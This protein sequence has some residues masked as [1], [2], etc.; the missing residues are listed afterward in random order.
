M[1]TGIIEEIGTV[2][3]AR[4]TEITVAAKKVIEDVHLGDSICVNGTC[5]T[6]T[7]FAAQTFTVGLSPE[8]LRRTNLINLRPGDPVN[9]EPALPVGGRMG[10]HYVQGHVDGVGRLVS[11]TPEG[12]SRIYTFSAPPELM[13]Y[14][15][16]KGFIALDGI[17]LTVVNCD[18][19]TFS[20]SMIPFTQRSVILG[21]KKPGYVVNIEVDILGKYVEK[22]LSGAPEKSSG[23]TEE[24]LA[25]YGFL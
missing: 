18:A 19:T 8:T 14:V 7:A 23:L 5:L 22:L 6:V 15:V 1:F 2:R 24:K 11:I 16:E 21:Q 13:R 12:D 17:S 20:I 10:G 25:K 4:E 9:L 3:L